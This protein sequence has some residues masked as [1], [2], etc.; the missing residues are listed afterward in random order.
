MTLFHFLET[1]VA[2]DVR[3]K[4]TCMQ[5]DRDGDAGDG[6]GAGG[7]EQ[8]GQAGTLHQVPPL[9]GL[10]SCGLYWVSKQY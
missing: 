1:W 2:T 6:A 8:T 4:M 3:L 7:D 10:V 9:T 5:S